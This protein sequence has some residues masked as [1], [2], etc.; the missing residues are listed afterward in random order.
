[1]NP[2]DFGGA[3]TSSSTTIRFVFVALSEKHCIASEKPHR[4]VGMAVGYFFIITVK[5]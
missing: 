1:M 5:R 4:A 3:M 2:K